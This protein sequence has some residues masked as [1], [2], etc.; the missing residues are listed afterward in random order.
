MC[1]SSVKELG[2]L[3]ENILGIYF[4]VAALTLCSVAVQLK[5][6]RLD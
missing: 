1:F 3:I 5:S 4:F 2:K 6:V